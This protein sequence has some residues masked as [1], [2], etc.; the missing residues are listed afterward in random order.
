MI[1]SIDV[2]KVFDRIQHSFM[3]K[4]NPKKVGK[5]AMHLKI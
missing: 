3:I 5:E 4:K 1:I 2:A